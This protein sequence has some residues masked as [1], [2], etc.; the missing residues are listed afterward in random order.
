MTFAKT[1]RVVGW[2]ERIAIRRSKVVRRHYSP[3]FHFIESRLR[4]SIG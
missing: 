3:G 2:I 1:H 4:N